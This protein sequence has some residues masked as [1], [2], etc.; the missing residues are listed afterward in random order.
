M[1]KHAQIHRF[2]DKVAMYVG[3]GETC[4]LTKREARDMAAALNAAVDDC[5]TRK[6]ADS[7]FST[8]RTEIEGLDHGE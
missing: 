1:S 7:E 5:K 2:H 4:Y 6:F 3:G 8:F